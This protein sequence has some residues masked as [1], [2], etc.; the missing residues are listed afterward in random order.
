M[1][2]MRPVVLNGTLCFLGFAW[3]MAIRSKK[4]APPDLVRFRRREE[5][6]RLLELFK[7]TIRPVFSVKQKCE[8]SS[9]D[10]SN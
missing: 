2:T 4:V 1:A 3:A 7:K 8:P 5:R 6:F 10:E 9:F